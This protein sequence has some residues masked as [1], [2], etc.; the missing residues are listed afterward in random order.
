MLPETVIEEFLN[1]SNVCVFVCVCV[2]GGGI[3]RTQTSSKLILRFL[4][5]ELSLQFFQAVIFA[6]TL[7]PVCYVP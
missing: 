3:D 7:S 2:G 1:S 5:K 6:A 4:L